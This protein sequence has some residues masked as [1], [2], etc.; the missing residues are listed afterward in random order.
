MFLKELAKVK[1]AKRGWQYLANNFKL[2][3][4]IQIWLTQSLDLFHNSTRVT[5]MSGLKVIRDQF[6]SP[7]FLFF[8]ISQKISFFFQTFRS[9]PFLFFFL[10][11]CFVFFTFFTFLPSSPSIFNFFCF[12]FNLCC[13]CCYC[14]CYCHCYCHCYYHYHSCGY[15]YHCHCYYYFCFD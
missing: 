5:F 4:N 13:L 3:V 12:Y 6:S 9:L 1:R 10:L 14:Y 11:L 2:I 15:H 7:R 8:F